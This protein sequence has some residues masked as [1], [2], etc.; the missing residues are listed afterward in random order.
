VRR[1]LV[2]LAARGVQQQ[3]R[4]FV[5]DADVPVMHGRAG[6]PTKPPSR[7][8]GTLK[9]HGGDRLVVLATQTSLEW[10]E[11]GLVRAPKF[12]LKFQRMRAYGESVQVAGLLS[13][14]LGYSLE[15]GH[16]AIEHLPHVTPVR[17]YGRHV[18]RA[19]RVLDTSGLETRVIRADEQEMQQA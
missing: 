19:A 13:H 18:M 3:T 2:Q 6:Q 9:L 12:Q 17:L 10:I 8:D 4:A 11:R 15:Q 7:D 14:W 16:A 5:F 1:R